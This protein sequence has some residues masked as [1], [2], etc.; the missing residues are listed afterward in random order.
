MD[1]RLAT[2]PLATGSTGLLGCEPS[3]DGEL[4]ACYLEK[5]RALTPNPNPNPN[6]S[7]NPNP[8]PNPNPQP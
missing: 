5:A 2:K 1:E 3:Q 6:P 7:P 4:W 8:N